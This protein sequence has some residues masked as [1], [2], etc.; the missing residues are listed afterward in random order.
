MEIPNLEEFSVL[1][2]EAPVRS[3]TRPTPEKH[4][5][6]PVTVGLITRIRTIIYESHCV[7]G[8]S[9]VLDS[10]LLIRYA[11]RY[12]LKMYSDIKAPC[13][14]FLSWAKSEH[15]LPTRLPDILSPH[16]Y[17][18]Y[19]IP[20]SFRQLAVLADA[21]A[22]DSVN[23][24]VMAAY[25]DSIKDVLSPQQLRIT[26]DKLTARLVPHPRLLATAA[27]A[28]FW[29]SVVEVYRKTYKTRGGDTRRKTVT[30]GITK[31]MC[32]DGFLVIK[33]TPDS[34][35]KLM[36]Y[37]QLQMIQDALL[38]RENTYMA[39]SWGLHNGS[40]RL[41]DLVSDLLDWQEECIR[42]HGSAGYELVKAPE[43]VYK[44]RIN[45]LTDGEI[46]SSS[47]FRRVIDKI[48]QKEKKIAGETRLTD[49]L[50]RTAL[51]VVSV[52]DCLELFGL[53][54]VSGHP[55]V[56]AEVSAA[57]VRAEASPYGRTSAVSIVN[58]VRV[59]KHIILSNYISRETNWP[60]FLIP[61][62]PGTLLH[63]HWISRTTVL[64]NS[65]YEL[66][67][68][69][70]IQFDKFAEFDYSD[71]FLKFL[72]DKAISPGA[73][74]THS[75]WFGN[76][77][78]TKRLLLAALQSSSLDLRHTVERLRRREFTLDE[79]IVELTQKER[80]LKGAARC[81]CKLALEVR[82]FFTLLEYNLAESIMT[83]YIPQQTMTMS[84]SQTKTRL[85]QM[86]Y[87]GSQSDR[88]GFLEIDFSRWNLR[89]RA[90]TVNPIAWVIEDIFGL[91]GAYSQVHWFFEHA[92]VVL[93]DRH[94]LPDGARPNTSAH[95]WPT[96]ALVWR[97]HKGG[98]EG[99]QQKLWTIC[100]ICMVYLALL[101]LAVVFILAGQ[102]DN[103]ILSLLLQDDTVSRKSVFNHLLARLDL[104]SKS[105]NHDVKPE[106]CIDS[107]SVIS[108]SKE[109]YV[110]GV[111]SMYTLK[112]ASRTLRRDDSDIPSLT[113]NISGVCASASAVADTLPAPMR[114]FLWQVYQVRRALRAWQ[115][116]A[117]C[118]TAERR[119]L[120]RILDDA[121]LFEHAVLWPGSLGG[122]P[123]LSF[124]RFLI[125]P[126]RLARSRH[127]TRVIIRF[128]SLLLPESHC[129]VSRINALQPSSATSIEASA[130]MRPFTRSS[131]YRLAALPR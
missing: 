101:G 51:T 69:D 104:F 35:W 20:P 68:L 129:Y 78:G 116:G 86:S 90:R 73:S 3:R 12:P 62:Q 87:K 107:A 131:R 64:P 119:A 105:L 111:H 19:F 22:A 30:V 83:P 48:R 84:S 66:A 43:A 114:A 39:L 91:P 25:T 24:K 56:Y 34:L 5:D 81:F 7:D 99:I 46:L 88:S 9:P 54:K 77:E 85:S 32:G 11:S 103:Q 97:G 44:A 23:R 21:D 109:F 125:K 65:S 60:P 13:L 50:E 94:S 72:D 57:A 124:T 121:R 37:E 74:K 53:I 26:L 96:S 18:D 82:C 28:D 128:R 89:W 38:A 10:R 36:T 17:P 33:L 41:D 49:R 126:N 58:S 2:Y 79:M 29:S 75:F 110:N 102:G 8:S 108:Y 63:R 100:T 31:L 45:S 47:S 52:G 95:E 112:F 71:D 122:L 130:L 59:F 120:S 1:E 117:D 27:A 42:L 14:Q 118:T 15:I 127:G 61:P 4:L 93:T 67:D 55:V 40:Q 80:E 106:E 76:L 123:V 16:D 92:T 115:Q 98:F 70:H 6:S 113:A